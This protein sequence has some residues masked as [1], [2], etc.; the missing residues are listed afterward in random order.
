MKNFKLKIRTLA[1][2][3]LVVAIAFAVWSFRVQLFPRSTEGSPAAKSAT[4][5]KS[6]RQ[7]VLEVGEQARK[8]F[9]LIVAPAKLQDQWRSVL[10]PGEIA[11]QPGLSDRGVTASAVGVVASIHVFPGDTVRP[12]EALFSLQLFSEYLQATQTQLFKAIRETGILNAEIERL[13]SG[14]NSGAI[15]QSRLIESRSEINRQATLAQSARQEL[16]NR[17]LSPEQVAKVETGSFVSSIDVKAPPRRQPKEL[18]STSGT[19]TSS[20]STP[21]DVSHDGGDFYYEVQELSVELGQQVQAGQLL[22]NLS[23]HQNLFVVGHAFKREA[24]SLE[25]AVQE[26]RPIEIEFSEDQADKWQP[27]NQS[28]EIRHLANT[29]DKNNRTFDFFIP[30]SNQSRSIERQGRSLKVWRFRPGQRAK[31]HIPVEKFTNVFVMPTEGVVREGAEAYV[32][33]QNGDLFKQLSVRILH[34]DRRHVIIANDGSIAIGSYLAQNAAASLNRILK[35]QTASGE[36][37]GL[38]VHPD[39]T[40][41]AAH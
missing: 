5:N 36:Q 35:A 16:L 14:V 27:L 11:D 6:E 12:G 38:H 21:S 28:F 4:S 31:L 33:R 10:I 9:G 7:T 24:A 17:G 40:T 15:P 26:Q 25:Q 2:P 41:H 30:L 20:T 22:V 3:L 32:F 8:N 34:E 37:P 13:S 29:I 39:G 19:A 23:N 1:G 18:G